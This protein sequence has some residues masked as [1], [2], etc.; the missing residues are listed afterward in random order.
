M[1]TPRHSTKQAV[2]SGRKF[3]HAELGLL[4]ATRASENAQTLEALRKRAKRTTSE[5]TQAMDNLVKKGV[6]EPKE[7]WDGTTVYGYQGNAFAQAVYCKIYQVDP[8]EL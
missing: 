4:Y 1:G 2:I 5:A 6:L 7:N 3:T 8:I